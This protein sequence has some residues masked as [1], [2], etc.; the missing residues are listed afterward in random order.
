MEIPNLDLTEPLSKLASYIH[1][2]IKNNT[3]KLFQNKFNVRITRLLEEINKA[4]D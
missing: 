4:N 3:N 2:S 1:T